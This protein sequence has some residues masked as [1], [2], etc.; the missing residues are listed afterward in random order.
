[1]GTLLQQAEMLTV[2]T[3]GYAYV[4]ARVQSYVVI[5]VDICRVRDLAHH[6]TP[7]NTCICGVG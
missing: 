5:K 4:G 3:S 6:A 7:Q 1:M 2:T